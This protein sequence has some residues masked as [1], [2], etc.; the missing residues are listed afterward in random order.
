MAPQSIQLKRKR[1]E[2]ALDIVY[3]EQPRQTKRLI[4]VFRRIQKPFKSKISTEENFNVITIPGIQATAP[5][6]EKKD[7]Y[8]LKQNGQ[9]TVI[10]QKEMSGDTK[11]TNAVPTGPRVFQFTR[12][13]LKR[14]STEDPD[15]PTFVEKRAKVDTKDERSAGDVGATQE[16]AGSLP[17]QAMQEPA[18]KRPS[19]AARIR[20]MPKVKDDSSIDPGLME[21]MQAFALEVAAEEQE[22]AP[23]AV[24]TQSQEEDDSMDIDESNTVYDVYVRTMIPVDAID[25]NDPSFGVLRIAEEDEEYWEQFTGDDDAGSQVADDEEDE[26]AEDWYGADYPEDELS[27][28]DERDETGTTYRRYRRYGSDDEEYGVGE[29]DEEK[30][31]YYDGNGARERTNENEVVGEYG[32]SGDEDSDENAQSDRKRMPWKGW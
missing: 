29:W 10:P 26:N 21:Q 30:Q 3:L 17:A 20:Q 9:S 28:D 5:G 4:E 1:D 23:R 25:F 7:P 27:S 14:K 8:A 31:R 22:K 11:G 16:T 2:E 32:A 18:R 19:K 13:N 15:I 6:A 24:S 12:P